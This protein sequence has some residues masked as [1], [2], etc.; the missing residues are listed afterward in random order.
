MGMILRWRYAGAFEFLHAN[1]DFDNTLIVFEIYVAIIHWSGFT[2]DAMIHYG[3]LDERVQL[4]VKPFS[5]AE[6]A[7][8]IHQ[9]LDGAP[10]FRWRDEY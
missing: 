10:W 5:K 3:R 4:L 7:L 2:K 8:K 9:I 6:F 1:A